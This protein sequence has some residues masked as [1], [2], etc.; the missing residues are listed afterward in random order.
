MGE[1]K[2]TTRRLW[3][4]WR[5]WWNRRTQGPDVLA[6][7]ERLARVARDR[8]PS[9]QAC[10]E[11]A[12]ALREALALNGTAVYRRAAAGDAWGLVTCSGQLPTAPT[13]SGELL[14]GPIDA[15]GDP[16]GLPA[17][18]GG[19]GHA[20]PAAWGAYVV[21]PHARTL[22]ALGRR[23]DGRAL[24]AI[25]LRLATVIGAQLD[26]FERA[27]DDAEALRQRDDDI[28]RL[29]GQLAAGT[30][31]A[32]DV[33]EPDARFPEIIGRSPVLYQAL[34]L[35]EKVATSTS[36]VLITGETGTGKELIARAIHDRSER[37]NGPLIN[38][39]C[40]AIPHHLAESELFGHE[41]GAFTDAVDARPGKFE[42]A[43]GG[44]IFLDEIAELPLPLQVKLLRV[45]QEREVQ[46]L[47]SRKTRRLDIR[48]VAATNRDLR[49]EMPHA[50]RDDLYYRLATVIIDVPALRERTDDI[51]ALATHFAT[52]AAG[53]AGKAIHGF[54][55]RALAM[56]RAYHWPGNIR[57]L[58][59]VVDRAVLLCAGDTIRPEH[60]TGFDA[61]CTD[62]HRLSHIV[63]DE[64]VRRVRDA[65]RQSNGNQAAA[66]RLLGM[67]R[68]NFGRLLKSLGLKTTPRTTGDDTGMREVG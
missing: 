28:R 63:R 18:L 13:L 30:L 62:D 60:L 5:R 1:S 42:L 25:D 41:R 31:A 64:K 29:E 37:R 3:Q 19:M 34:H 48:I 26:L 16:L 36:S 61:Y 15:A 33:G 57:E 54:T 44:T 55:G 9:P 59:N 45:L 67:S 10:A 49:A 23:R 24:K 40:P 38:V 52:A 6:L 39:N 27:A 14:P 58:R 43:D 11:L 4:D 32:V 65:L 50:F 56:L 47:G 20:A 7:L 22:I 35:V 53:G 46:R 17:A 68:S 51:P 12:L 66:A 21:A 8:T 2:R